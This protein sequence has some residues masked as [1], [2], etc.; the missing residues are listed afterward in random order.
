[1][2]W[3]P[4]LKIKKA[5]G[6]LGGRAQRLPLNALVAGNALQMSIWSSFLLS[7]S[8]LLLLLFP[9]TPRSR[10]FFQTYSP[11]EIGCLCAF[12]TLG[13]RFRVSGGG[14]CFCSRFVH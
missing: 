14:G 7:S 11:M 2:L 6:G 1:M 10:A 3:G 12:P 13:V 9:P 8:W 5:G 4:T